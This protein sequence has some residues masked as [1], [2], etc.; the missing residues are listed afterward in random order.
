MVIKLTSS[1]PDRLI[2]IVFLMRSMLFSIAS[3]CQL[4]SSNPN[5]RNTNV[6]LFGYGVTNEWFFFL[7]ISAIWSWHWTNPIVLRI[8]IWKS[9]LKLY[10]RQYSVCFY[11]IWE[12]SKILF[13]SRQENECSF[14]RLRLCLWQIRKGFDY[15]VSDGHV[16][17]LYNNNTTTY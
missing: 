11:L 13:F 17:C 5:L 6:C 10:M 14:E 2:Q 8:I 9:Y 7:D 12:L 1:R 16:R 4:G 15:E 3:K